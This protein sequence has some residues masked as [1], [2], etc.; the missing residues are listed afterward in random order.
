MATTD[1]RADQTVTL[2]SNTEIP[3][4]EVADWYG[5]D[6]EVVVAIKP[7]KSLLW[8]HWE[9]Q[10]VEWVHAEDCD[11]GPGVDGLQESI[12]C[13]HQERV[14]NPENF[15]YDEV[16]EPGVYCTGTYYDD[17]SKV[18]ES[19]NIIVPREYVTAEQCH[20]WIQKLNQKYDRNFELT[21]SADQL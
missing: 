1:D 9:T 15:D 6:G 20:K 16:P 3:F 10:C 8:A 18:D 5:T 17:E 19:Y 2:W 11:H 14:V 7:M 21:I 12:N 13:P 4:E